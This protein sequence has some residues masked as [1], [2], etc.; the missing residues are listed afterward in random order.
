MLQL[1]ACGKNPLYFS[2]LLQFFSG[3][4]QDFLKVRSQ[5][6]IISR[7]EPVDFDR[8]KIRSKPIAFDQAQESIPIGFSPQAI[9]YGLEDDVEKKWRVR[10]VDF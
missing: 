6:L 10:R 9:G 8:I 5:V 3:N 1:L 2:L 4:Q 7:P